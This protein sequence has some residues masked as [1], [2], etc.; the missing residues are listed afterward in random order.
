MPLIET[1]SIRRAFT[2]CVAA[3]TLASVVSGCS[4]GSSAPDCRSYIWPRV[5][6]EFGDT[7]AESFE[8]AWRADD[9]LTGYAGACNSLGATTAFQCSVAIGGNAAEQDITVF[10]VSGDG[11]DVILTRDVPLTPFNTMGAGVAL[12]VAT[13]SDAGAPELSEPQYV[14]ACSP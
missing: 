10:V 13:T 7:G 4:G 6:I 5:V 9:G 12:L 11:G 1:Q 3:G 14:D 8:Y 2:G